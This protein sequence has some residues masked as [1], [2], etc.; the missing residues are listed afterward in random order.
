MQ[1][2]AAYNASLPVVVAIGARGVAEL[3]P[4]ANIELFYSWSDSAVWPGNATPAEGDYVTIPA[5]SAV[6]LDGPPP[7]LGGL[8]VRGT[9]VFADQVLVC[10]GIFPGYSVCPTF[11]LIYP[12]CT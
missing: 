8:T 5:G 10:W 6:L 11:L 7:P 9:L 2:S 4:D 12:A 1:G 3:A